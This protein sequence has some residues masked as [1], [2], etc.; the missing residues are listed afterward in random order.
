MNSFKHNFKDVI[1]FPIFPDHPIFCLHPQTLGT[2]TTD[3][4]MCE[5]N[6]NLLERN[7]PRMSVF[8]SHCLL[9]PSLHPQQ[10]TAGIWRNPSNGRNFRSIWSCGSVSRRPGTCWAWP[11][12][13]RCSS[14]F[15]R[16]EDCT[17]ICRCCSTTFIWRRSA[18]GSMPAWWRCINPTS[19][20]WN[21]DAHRTKRNDD[22]LQSDSVFQFVVV[23]YVFFLVL[24]SPRGNEFSRFCSIIYCSVCSRKWQEL[25]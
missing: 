23:D 14:T 24:L 3:Q 18:W 16:A 13:G 17:T 15:T 22:V 4:S 10:L 6:S 7:R 1:H 12:H 19:S 8:F 9:H 2:S 20:K 25:T 21:E 11:R 5:E